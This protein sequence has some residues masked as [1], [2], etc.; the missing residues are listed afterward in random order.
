MADKRNLH[1]SILKSTRNNTSILKSKRKYT[2]RCNTVQ[3]MK[4]LWHESFPNTM[5]RSIPSTVVLKWSIFPDYILIC[6][7][8]EIE[9]AESA[10]TTWDAPIPAADGSDKGRISVAWLCHRIPTTWRRAE[11]GAW[12]GSGTCARTTASERSKHTV[13][14]Q[15]FVPLFKIIE[16]VSV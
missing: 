9:M 3:Y 12:C 15:R 13:L 1:A 10:C 2:H 4:I 16:C 6:F 5:R 8:V 11:T 14:V 7:S